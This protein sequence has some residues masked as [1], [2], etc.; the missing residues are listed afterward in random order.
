M[1]ALGDT[2][3]GIDEL[4]AGEWLGKRFAL[5][6]VHLDGVVDDL[7]QFR[8][9]RLG[10]PSMATTV[11]QLRATA[12]K[13]LILVLQFNQLDVLITFAHRF[14]SSIANRTALSW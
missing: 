9:N 7:A 1:P 4:T 10:I 14:D 8:E 2:L 13:A 5:A 3:Q 12:D 11:E 6:F